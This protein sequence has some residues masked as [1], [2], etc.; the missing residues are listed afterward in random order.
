MD[1][2]VGEES[3]SNRGIRRPFLLMLRVKRRIL[4]SSENMQNL[5]VSII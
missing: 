1:G 3:R 2:D 5:V 4:V